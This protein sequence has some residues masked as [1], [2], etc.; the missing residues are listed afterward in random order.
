MRGRGFPAVG[1]TCRVG[2]GGGNA[3]TIASRS[4]PETVRFIF[5]A[6]RDDVFMVS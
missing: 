1:H 2:F 3:F 6:I 4:D 5:R